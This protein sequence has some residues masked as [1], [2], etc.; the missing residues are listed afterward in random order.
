MSR[1]NYFT[2]TFGE[3]YDIKTH[4]LPREH[5]FYPTC[6]ENLD[7]VL[8]F[9]GKDRGHISISYLLIPKIFVGESEGYPESFSCVMEPTMLVEAK[10]EMDMPFTSKNGVNLMYRPL[11]REVKAKL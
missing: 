2:F 11:D 5:K 7:D 8:K 6:I 1:Q 4:V 9:V 3:T 10:G